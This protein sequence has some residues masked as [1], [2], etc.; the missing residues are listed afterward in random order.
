MNNASPHDLTEQRL[1]RD[2]RAAASGVPIAPGS[3][4]A[5]VATGRRRRHRRRQ[6]N[7]IMLVAATGFGTALTIRQLARTGE[8]S[9]ATDTLPIDLP[10]ESTGSVPES[11]VPAPTAP[12]DTSVAPETTPGSVPLETAVGDIPP[13]QIVAS[14]M[15]WTVIEPDSTQAVGYGNVML[16][17]SGP[18]VA[19]ATSP[20]RSNDY[21]PQLWRSDDGVSWSPIDVDVP[22]GSLD[23]ARFAGD[24]VYVVGTAPGIPMS[25]PNPLLF[26]VSGD[27][28]GLW[29]QVELPVDTNAGRDLPY[30]KGLSSTAAVY[31]LE[32]GAA[33]I[34]YSGAMLDWDAIAEQLGVPATDALAGYSTPEGVYVATDPGC[35]DT[36]VT[37][38]TV[39]VFGQGA[40]EMPPPDGPCGNLVT[41]DAIGVPQETV[42]L[43]F[44]LTPR[45]FLVVGDQVTEIAVPD[46]VRGNYYYNDP[47]KALFSSDDGRWYVMGDDGVMVE[48][49][50]GPYGGYP[51][52]S[53]DGT[54]FVQ[55][56][57]DGGRFGTNS[58]GVGT[59]VQGGPW[60]YTDW[61]DLVGEDQVAF[62]QQAAVTGAGLVQIFQAA[63]DGIAAQGGIAVSSGGFTASRATA[64]SPVV[65]TN[66]ATGESIDLTRV[67]FGDRGVIIT[68]AD[69]NQI[70]TMDGPTF[71]SILSDPRNNGVIDDFLVA[72]S[73]DGE[74]VSV[75]SISGL[76]GVDPSTISWVP[77]IS[78]AGN[79]TVI[80]VTMKE[81][82]ADGVPRQL[83]LV[84]TP[85]S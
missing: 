50:S 52:G 48:T 83:V 71:Q 10:T 70:G 75:D 36:T 8:S 64:K 14:N 28:G 16:A 37:V 41:W 19:L 82:N 29:D 53:N 57:P 47:T 13:A 68:D 62:S 9:V 78:S 6:A 55:I 11:A 74:H 34:L 85:N 3:E 81:R 32:D 25:Q 26:G 42:D 49:A 23:R 17:A 79:T 40:F 69:G 5:V 60:T 7:A 72:V 38:G 15:T 77:R 27:D 61:S 63:P 24:K 4:V 56:S 35:P 45:E 22:F 12:I 59:S 31:P 44:G 76:L 20:G 46:G 33:V 80:A 66:D 84:G 43:A 58:T 67:F 21:T 65:I 39:P 73:A 51:V 54:M 2:L 30:V 18:A 1:A